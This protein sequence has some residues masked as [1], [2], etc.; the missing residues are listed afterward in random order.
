ML[1]DLGQS[2]ITKCKHI[3]QIFFYVLFTNDKTNIGQFDDP[4]LKTML[5]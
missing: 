5:N 2:Y 4:L 3:T 1:T